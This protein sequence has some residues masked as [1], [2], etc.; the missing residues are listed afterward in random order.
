MRSNEDEG[1]GEG[2]A[3][4]CFDDE[5]VGGGGT[6]GDGEGAGAGVR[7]RSG[8]ESDRLTLVAFA[9]SFALPGRHVT[10]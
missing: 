6:N 2:S 7:I 8:M 1:V 3:K 9:S 5:A 4:E 10:V